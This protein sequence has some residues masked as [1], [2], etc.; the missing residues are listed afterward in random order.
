[1]TQE[2]SQDRP[3]D[4]LR[5]DDFD[6]MIRHLEQLRDRGYEAA[7]NWSLGGIARHLRLFMTESMD[8]FG[9][10]LPWFLYPIRLLSKSILRRTLADRTIKPG[11]PTMEHWIPPEGL[12]DRVEVDALIATIRRYRAHDAPLHASPLFG[13]LDRE[14]WDQVHLIHGAHHLS[15]LRARPPS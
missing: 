2:L 1:M 14:T 8:G 5:F 4:G 12:D 13:R 9:A 3:S 7:G 6:A 11:S 10:K 15:F